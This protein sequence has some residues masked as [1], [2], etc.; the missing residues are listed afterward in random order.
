MHLKEVRFSPSPLPL[1][2]N[3]TLLHQRDHLF[4]WG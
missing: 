1:P 4:I 3:P 2:W